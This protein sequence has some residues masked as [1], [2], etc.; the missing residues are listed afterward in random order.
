MKRVKA[1]HDK[2]AEGITN[3]IGTM[4]CAYLFAALA[5]VS[6]PAAVR[7]QNLLVL[8]GWVAQTFLQLV[9]LSVIL[10][11]SKLSARRTEATINATHAEATEL[12]G[13]MHQILSEIADQHGNLHHLCTEMDAVVR[14]VHANVQHGPHFR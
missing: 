6:L 3:A 7:S 2:L 13:D 8:V 4:L 9:L 11:G 12:L 10:L 14:A 5:L 1:L